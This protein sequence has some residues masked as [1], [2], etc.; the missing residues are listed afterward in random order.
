ME[1]EDERKGTKKRR[2]KGNGKARPKKAKLN[3]AAYDDSDSLGDWSSV[4]PEESDEGSGGKELG[5]DASDKERMIEEPFCKKAES[6]RP[7][8][9]LFRDIAHTADEGREQFVG[10]ISQLDNADIE[11]ET[12]Y[13]VYQAGVQTLLD[14]RTYMEVANVLIHE[15]R[16][17]FGIKLLPMLWSSIDIRV[18][19]PTLTS[20]AGLIMSARLAVLFG[21]SFNI[22]VPRE[23]DIHSSPLIPPIPKAQSNHQDPK[24]WTSPRPQPI[25]HRA[26]K[27]KTHPRAPPFPHRPLLYPK[28]KPCPI[29]LTR[30]P[31]QG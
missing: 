10:R 11:Q 15:L 7:R 27:C 20:V 14:T 8:P 19:Y 13:W 2:R 3:P 23:S 24:F 4:P 18:G 25:P 1:N 9:P 12:N 31:V 17:R 22:N 6:V 26:P 21:I 16:D 29:C 30:N 28:F 5:Y